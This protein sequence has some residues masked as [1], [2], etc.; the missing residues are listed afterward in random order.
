[1]IILFSHFLF[2]KDIPVNQRLWSAWDNHTNPTGIVPAENKEA[3]HIGFICVLTKRQRKQTSGLWNCDDTWRACRGLWQGQLGNSLSVPRPG[4][5][6]NNSLDDF[7]LQASSPS[8]S[9]SVDEVQAIYTSTSY[10]QKKGVRMIMNTGQRPWRCWLYPHITY[11]CCSPKLLCPNQ[12]HSSQYHF[13][14]QK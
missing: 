10:D 6:W 5:D 1:M 4:L 12:L 9:T 2:I 3:W 11:Q 14:L 7:M 8:G 13:L